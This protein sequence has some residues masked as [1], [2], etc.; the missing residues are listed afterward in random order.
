MSFWPSNAVRYTFVARFVV[1]FDACFYTMYVHLVPLAVFLVVSWHAYCTPMIIGLAS[2][3]GNP[4]GYWGAPRTTADHLFTHF[5]D[6]SG[7]IL[8][9]SGNFFILGWASCKQR[10]NRGCPARFLI[11]SCLSLGPVAFM[12]QLHLVA[13]RGSNASYCQVHYFVWFKYEHGTHS[14]PDSPGY[15]R[16]QGVTLPR[17]LDPPGYAE[18]FQGHF[19]AI[20]CVINVRYPTRGLAPQSHHHT[21]ED[22]PGPC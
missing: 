12:A 1:S 8:D 2:I 22:N 11:A 16:V 20:D 17:L 6:S 7:L 13:S 9:A 5:L 4:N 14:L 3:R 18:C 10:F 19:V 21:V 15:A